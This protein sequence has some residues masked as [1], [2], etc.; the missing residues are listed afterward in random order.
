MLVEPRTNHPFHFY[1]A[2]TMQSQTWAE[3]VSRVRPAAEQ[4]ASRLSTARQIFL[5]GIG[6]SFSAAQLGYYFFSDVGVPVPVHAVHA[7]DF[8]L[9]GPALSQDDCVIV[10]SHRGTKQYSLAALKRARAAGCYTLLITGQQAPHSQDAMATIQTTPQEKASAF[11]FS[12]M[13]ALAVLAVLAEA[14]GEQCTG[15]KAH[16]PSLL[17][18]QIPNLLSVCLER[19]KQVAALATKH[20]HRRR[21][22]L[23]GGGPLE[24]IAQEIAMKIK[25]TSYLQ[26]EGMSSEAILHGPFQCVEP[27][28]LF[29]LLA[30]AGAAQS[31]LFPLAAMIKD[32]GASSLVIDDGSAIGM[33][34]DADGS[35]SAPAISEPY[36][37]LPCLVLLQ[38]FCYHL[39]LGVGTNPDSFRLE[40]PR[41]AAARKRVQL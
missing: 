14:A 10:V 40:D 13:G 36:T 31:R 1:D 11:T 33:Y 23:V 37:A 30:P 27:E 2:L 22:W 17:E 28:D 12:F 35:C 21:M 29:L 38:L 32:I 9:Y 3:V 7:F 25:E 18:Q 34:Q 4:S 39:A 41:F 6:T 15:A 19:E 20:L 16:S 26:A 24:V 8:V 5:V